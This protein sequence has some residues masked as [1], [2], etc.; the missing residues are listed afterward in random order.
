METV[1]HVV[2]ALCAQMRDR[3]E[4]MGWSPFGAWTALLGR[5][6]GKPVFKPV[7]KY[8]QITGLMTRN[9]DTAGGDDTPSGSEAP[10]KEK[11]K[12]KKLSP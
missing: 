5:I 12:K 7:F 1:D 3:G 11:K 4:G 10:L 8:L 2:S 9:Q 6:S